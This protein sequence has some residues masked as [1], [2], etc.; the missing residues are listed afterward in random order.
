[1][2]EC[3]RRAQD[4]H[5]AISRLCQRIEVP[6]YLPCQL[7]T[8]DEKAHFGIDTERTAVEVHGS[9]ED[10]LTIQYKHLA[11]QCEFP[12]RIRFDAARMRAR[13][14]RRW[15]HFAHIYTVLEQ[16]LAVVSIANV[17]NR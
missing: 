16:L 3:I 2:A 17:R 7:R 8:V 11:V 15:P 9:D 5:I 13:C 6:R 10:A 4:R 12:W 14:V 1:M